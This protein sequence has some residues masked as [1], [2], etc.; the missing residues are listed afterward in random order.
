MILKCQVLATSFLAKVSRVVWSVA[1]GAA[2][3][4]KVSSN[5][6]KEQL[7]QHLEKTSAEATGDGPVC[8]VPAE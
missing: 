1:C 2:R 8:V 3:E 7:E 5:L 6:V 4:T